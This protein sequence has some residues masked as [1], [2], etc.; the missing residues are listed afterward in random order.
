MSDRNSIFKVAFDVVSRFVD[1]LKRGDLDVANSML[2][3]TSC[4]VIDDD[5]VYL[6]TGIGTDYEYDEPW[7]NKF[8]SLDQNIEQLSY[9]IAS[10]TLARE[11]YTF[12]DW[13]K[14]KRTFHFS[15]HFLSTPSA[16]YAMF[17][18]TPLNSS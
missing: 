10:A 12:H 14:R 2:E 1:A 16:A 5:D 6:R 3:E 17:F 7:S 18:H 13:V 9:D 11:E 8:R 4:F 15:S